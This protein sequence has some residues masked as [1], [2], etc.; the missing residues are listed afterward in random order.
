MPFA[1][2][3]VATP[4]VSE[5]ATDTIAPLPSAKEI[6]IDPNS[7]TQLILLQ[8]DFPSFVVSADGQF[9]SAKNMENSSSILYGYLKG[10]LLNV[11]LEKDQSHVSQM[12]AIIDTK[13]NASKIYDQLDAQYAPALQIQYP[14]V[15]ITAHSCNWRSRQ[16]VCV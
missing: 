2:A 3:A 8:T 7:L 9:N 14:N 11:V 10:Y 6:I 13:A 1:P 4:H 15:S 16:D 5:S 12:I